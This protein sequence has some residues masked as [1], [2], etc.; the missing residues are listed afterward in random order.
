MFIQ[1]IIL[2]CHLFVR[3][4]QN[5]L[6]DYFDKMEQKTNWDCENNDKIKWNMDFNKYFRIKPNL[7]VVTTYKC[8]KSDKSVQFSFT[9]IIKNSKLQ[10]YGSLE[11]LK[12]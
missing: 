7:P 10:G 8:T 4:Y 11:I 2:S 5:K 9:G 1:I 12:K 6:T 3:T